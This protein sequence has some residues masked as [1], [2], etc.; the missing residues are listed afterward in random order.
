M[1]KPRVTIIGLGLI[2]GSIGLALKASTRPIDVIGHDIDP[3]VG[4]LAQKKDAV[5]SNKINIHDA[6]EGADVVVI[7][8]PIT[9]IQETLEMIGPHLKQGCV[10]TDTARLKQPVLTWATEALPS[11]V[12]YVGGDPLLNPNAV[13]D[14]VTLPHGLEMARAD[15]FHRGLYALCPSADASPGAVKRIADMINLLEARA[16]FLDPAE[17]DGMRAGVDGLPLLSGLALMRHVSGSPG[18]QESRKLADYALGMTTALFVGDPAEQSAQLSLNAPSLL[19]R[20]DALIH[21]LALL[22]EWIATQNSESLDEALNQAGSARASWLSDWEA[23]KW[24]EELADLGVQGTLGSLGD[25]LG[26]GMA[27]RERKEE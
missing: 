6:C 5:D 25:M 4:R 10:V 2:G 13:G 27:K 12:A 7:A 3:S 8:T 14:D 16:L 1:T 21:E 17:H 11:G 18:W 22:R 15:L 9:A 19:P 26:L 20:I 24:D 23:G